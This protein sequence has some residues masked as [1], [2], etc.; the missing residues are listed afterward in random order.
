MSLTSGSKFTVALRGS[1][2]TAWLLMRIDAIV[3]SDSAIASTITA[4]C[5]GCDTVVFCHD[6]EHI[7]ICTAQ[8]R[9][10]T[11]A[12]AARLSLPYD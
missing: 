1:P 11:A 3:L 10:P 7:Y 9:E 5:T 2:E 12:V 8:Q 6:S 4:A